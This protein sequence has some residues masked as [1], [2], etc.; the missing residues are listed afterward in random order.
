MDINELKNI[1]FIKY[2]L[3]SNNKFNTKKYKK[4]SD[5][6]EYKIKLHQ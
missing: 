4:T 6:D 1:D 2:F 5:N 3:M